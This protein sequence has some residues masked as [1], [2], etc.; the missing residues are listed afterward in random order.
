MFLVA[1]LL[2]H[3]DILAAQASSPVSNPPAGEV[4]ASRWRGR[5]FISPMG[6]PFR[7]AGKDDDTLADWFRQADRQ[8]DGRLTLEE[9]KQDADRLFAVLDLNHDGEIDPEEIT[10]YE[11]VVAP[12]IQ[13][14]EHFDFASTEVA[15]GNSGEGRGP[16]THGRREGSPAASQHRSG[17]FS[18]SS[19]NDRHQGAGR[20]GLLDLPEPVVAAD[21]DF[22]RGVSREEFRAAAE[23]RFLALDL[24]HKGYLTL[25]DLERIR[26]APAVAPKPPDKPT[27]PD[28]SEIPRGPSF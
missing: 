13:T 22:D 16:D 18:R 26:P 8:H 9:M 7:P 10:H 1:L 2:W 4:F 15:D 25:G 20:Y 5:L 27:N 28:E 17:G 6:E 11:E 3:A 14:G 19:G 12:E 23:Q 24:D 21:T